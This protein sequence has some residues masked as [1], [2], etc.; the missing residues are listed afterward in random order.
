MPTVVKPFRALIFALTLAAVGC[1]AQTP[2]PAGGKL[3]PELARRVE[4][5]IRSK[6][7]IPPDY[8]IQIGPRTRSEVP[9]FDA[10]DVTF[11]TKDKSSKPVTFLLSTD[12]KTLAQF[13]KYDISKDPKLLVSGDGRPARGGP[14]NAPVLIVGFDDLE[15]PYCA[16][17]HQ[18][19]FPALTERYKNQIHI[20]YRDFP[21]DQH[22]W[23]MRAAINTNCVAAQSPAG[24]WNLVDYIHA[25]ASEMGGEEKS[26]AKAN[27]MLDSLA[28]DEGKRQKL[29]ADT[30]N[31]CLVKQDDTA[32]K[33]SMKLGESLGVDSTPAFFINGEKIEGA[34]PLEYVYRMIDNALIASG[35]TPPPPPPAAPTPTQPQNPPASKPGN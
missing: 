32:V 21:L 24:Y 1:H 12:G 30:L 10:I 17:M 6:S 28:R 11:V 20:V 26:L 31:A 19:L 27:D 25:H 13:S 15:C 9:G 2:M 18:Q 3:S 33:A 5:L 22:P 23:A 8:D 35:Q 4:V 34:L 14:A 29:N 7:S 16:K